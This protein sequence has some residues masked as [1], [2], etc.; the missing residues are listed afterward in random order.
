ML[1][2]DCQC[3]RLLKLKTQR[4]YLKEYFMNNKFN[5]HRLFSL[6]AAFFLVT[7]LCSYAQTIEINSNQS[8]TITNPG[9][10]PF[11]TIGNNEL[12]NDFN[13]G[14]DIIMVQVSNFLGGPCAIAP[15]ADFSEIGPQT[16]VSGNGPI[17]FDFSGASENSGTFG[18]SLVPKTGSCIFDL[19]ITPPQVSTS[20]SSGN[21]ITGNTIVPNSVTFLGGFLSQGL[22]DQLSNDTNNKNCQTSPSGINPA[23]FTNDA[24]VNDLYNDLLN[25]GPSGREADLKEFL[26]MS[27][28]TRYFTLTFPE[29]KSSAMTVYNQQLSNS[30]NMTKIYVTGILPS[31]TSE[32]ST[33]L[34]R[35]L[36]P[37]IE[38]T[39]ENQGGG[40]LTA[41]AAVQHAIVSATMPWQ[42]SSGN[43]FFIVQGGGC[44]GPYC[45][46]VESGMVV[47]VPGGACTPDKLSK[48]RAGYPTV[49]PSKFFDP[50][51]V[52]SNTIQ[53]PTENVV[54]PKH[55]L[56]A[57]VVRDMAYFIFQ[58]VPPNSMIIQQLKIG[59]K[60]S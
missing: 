28:D 43:G 16:I 10:F 23:P 17:D 6:L 25:R 19:F 27:E 54:D 38:V 53:I 44:V 39:L 13:Q 20:S 24:F 40:D 37:E 59:I 5:L 46:I 1:C 34:G 42:L 9:F 60:K 57:K 18:L 12:K 30:T 14:N 26:S 31:S 51:P 35:E 56:V 3:N 58:P 22:T 48:R 47:I 29:N 41:L 49:N 45:T 21:I 36:S 7:V 15:A 2:T 52:A 55:P 4:A 50:F 8:L 32:N 33:M 11:S